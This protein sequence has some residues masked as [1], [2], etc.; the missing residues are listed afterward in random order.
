[1]QLNYIQLYRMILV[2]L[3]SFV[4][5][6]E[7]PFVLAYMLIVVLLPLLFTMTKI[8]YSKTKQDD[9]FTSKM[10]KIIMLLGI[11]SVVVISINII[12]AE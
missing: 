7:V 1:M 4:N 11:L 6:S 8:L 3:Y 12:Y 9:A 2:T 5:F 10:L